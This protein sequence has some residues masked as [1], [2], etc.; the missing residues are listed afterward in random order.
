MN[1][2]E[3]LME[4]LM[5]ESWL[6]EETKVKGINRN[7]PCGKSFIC[8]DGDYFCSDACYDRWEEINEEE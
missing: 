1:L 3:K 4:R 7:C 5:K 8:T 6:V 2:L